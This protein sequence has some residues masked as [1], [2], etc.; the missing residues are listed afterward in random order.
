MTRYITVVAFCVFAVG[1]PAQ[2]SSPHVHNVS[3]VDGSKNPELIPDS[4]AYRLY[5]HNLSV[6]ANASEEQ[7]K[8]QS[9]RLAKLNLSVSDYGQVLI[10]LADFRSRYDAWIGR[11]NAEA[12]QKREHFDPSLLWQESEN[13][14]TDTQRALQTQL[15]VEGLF[16]FANQVQQEKKHMQIITGGTQ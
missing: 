8:A 12:Q 10:I 1:T 14:V 6:P 5:L 4:T 2:I 13:I 11:W 15:S 3:I 7:V 9:S 16:R